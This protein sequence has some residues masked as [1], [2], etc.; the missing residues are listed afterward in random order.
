MLQLPL[1]VDQSIRRMA[2]DGRGLASRA[3]ALRVLAAVDRGGAS[4]RLLDCALR[5]TPLEDR[6]RRLIT[7]IVYGTLRRQSSIDRT[8]Q[9][10]CRRPLRRLH[11]EV[12]A[13]MRMAVYQCA[14]L[15]AIP[16]YAALDS[17]VEVLKDL[18]PAA[19][20]LANAVLRAWQRSGGEIDVGRVDCLADQSDVPE[21]LAKRWRR[22]Y[23]R[24]RAAAW[25]E[26]TLQPRPLVLRAHQEVLPSQELLRQLAAE[27][28]VVV[29]SDICPGALRVLSGNVLATKAFA[30]GA[31]SLRSEAAQMVTSLLRC[32]PAG[33]IL[34]ACSGRGGKAIQLAEDHELKFL[35][36]VDLDAERLAV[37]RQLADRSRQISLMP[38]VADLAAPLP[39]GRVFDAALVDVPC[40]GLGTIARHPEIK[41]RVQLQSLRRLAMLQRAILQSCATAL[42]PG[43]ELLYVT[44]STE[45]EEN[46]A[47]V[48]AVAAADARLQVM[49]IDTPVGIDPGF[50]GS[51]GYLRT[52][53]SYPQLDGFFAARL[54]VREQVVRRSDDQRDGASN[55][56]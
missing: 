46:E 29:A 56:I 28:V 12:R 2:R 34:D 22:R 24:R 5:A 19:A 47:V 50:V 18:R 38:V 27:E 39:F 52:Y 14:F 49:P 37:G 10:F 33:R 11:P 44:C 48:E 26:A 51:D 30:M 55:V 45:P 8:L 43:G 7:E 9:P 40:S 17:A 35:T 3:L 23:G 15:R 42:V 36:A 16:V 13:A 4:D 54:R 25:F 1:G 6:D 32:R 20:R 31:F 41:W 53:P 21:W